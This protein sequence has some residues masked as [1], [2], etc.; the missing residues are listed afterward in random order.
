MATPP[1]TTRWGAVGDTVALY[2]SYHYGL[3]TVVMVKINRLTAT[4]VV[5][6]G[7]DRRFRRDDG[8]EWGNRQGKTVLM[9]PE[10]AEVQNAIAARI[11]R[12]L[13]TPLAK[14]VG[15]VRNR[16][17][18]LQALHHARQLLREAAI[19]LGVNHADLL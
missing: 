4:Q 6:G 14:A 7:N 13:E 3:P 5:V 16:Q 11:V 15:G 12:A 19:E 18:A 9:R 17:Q 10:A 8:S 2:N 1:E